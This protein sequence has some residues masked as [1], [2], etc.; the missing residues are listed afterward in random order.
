[1]HYSDHFQPTKFTMASRRSGRAADQ[2]SSR[3]QYFTDR[4]ENRSPAVQAAF[5]AHS[6]AVRLRDKVRLPPTL[7]PADR[8]RASVLRTGPGV[9][10]SAS[11]L[12]GSSSSML[13]ASVRLRSPVGRGCACSAATDG[14]VSRRAGPRRRRAGTSGEPGSTGQVASG[15]GGTMAPPADT[16]L[17]WHAWG[18]GRS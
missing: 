6:V 3:I 16:G 15:A 8:G 2:I 14:A 13:E 18:A 4:S 11:R 17:K 9:E 1:M 5:Q 7:A 12:T 10:N